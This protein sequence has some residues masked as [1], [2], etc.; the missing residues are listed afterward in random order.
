LTVYFLT[1]ND[2]GEDR[3][4]NEAPQRRITRVRECVA[5]LEYSRQ[6]TLFDKHVIGRVSNKKRDL[7]GELA[8]IPKRVPFKWQR[9]N[10]IGRT[11]VCKNNTNHEMDYS[12]KRGSI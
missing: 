6:T 4:D 5:A 9:G 11:L 12:I 8:V 10:K 1:G 3:V 7:A 2:P